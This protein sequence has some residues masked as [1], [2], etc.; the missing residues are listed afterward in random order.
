VAVVR[1]R[2][3]DLL[4]TASAACSLYGYPGVSFVAGAD[5]HQVGAP[6][7]RATGSAVSLV[8]VAPGRAARAMLRAVDAG[9]YGS[10]CRITPVL[11]FRVYP[12]DNTQALFVPYTTQGCANPAIVTLGIGPLGAA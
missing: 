2:G 12:P 11:G 8:V 5:G 6:A 10:S 3:L 7:K 9:D 4:N 1:A